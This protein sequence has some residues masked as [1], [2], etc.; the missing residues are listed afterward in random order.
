[1]AANT[2]LD[3]SQLLLALET[4]LQSSTEIAEFKGEPGRRSEFHV[5]HALGS[6][7]VL[8]TNLTG[9]RFPKNILTEP[10]GQAFSAP[11]PRFAVRLIQAIDPSVTFLEV[12]AALRKDQ[13][14]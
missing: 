2:N 6:L 10:D 7:A 5:D 12:K 8:W 3:F 9:R 14:R 13:W 11:G 4:L 1:K